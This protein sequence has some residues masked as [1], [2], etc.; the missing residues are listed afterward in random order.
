M[1]L[2]S[3][4]KEGGPLPS[5]EKGDSVFLLYIQMRDTVSLLYGEEK[6][7]LFAIEERD[8]V[9]R[10]YIERGEC[11]SSLSRRETMFVFYIEMKEPLSLLYP[12][13][14]GK[15]RRHRWER[16]GHRREGRASHQRKRRGHLGL[17]FPSP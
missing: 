4:K 8:S 13:P 17:A 12:P 7:C 2:F 1:S 3:K 9:S 5:I 16:V 6:A 10:L 11:V 15:A 14:R